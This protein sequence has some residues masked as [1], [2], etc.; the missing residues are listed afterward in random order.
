MLN[1]TMSLVDD[2]LVIYYQTEFTSD[3]LMDLS[4]NMRNYVVP[5]FSE[6]TEHMRDLQIIMD[7][8][9]INYLF[10]SLFYREK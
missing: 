10:F 4:E 1:E 8:N 9:Y 6:N 7:E 5:K 3:D 2:H